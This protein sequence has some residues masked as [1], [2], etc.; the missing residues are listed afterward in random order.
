MYVFV[1]VQPHSLPLPLRPHLRLMLVA[2]YALPYRLSRSLALV[3]FWLGEFPPSVSDCQSPASRPYLRAVSSAERPP[4]DSAPPGGGPRARGAARRRLAGAAEQR[5]RHR[6]AFR[7]AAIAAR[8]GTSCRHVLRSCHSKDFFNSDTSRSC[9]RAAH[10]P[11]AAQQRPSPRFGACALRRG[12]P[13]RR[14][15]GGDGEGGGRGA[16]RGAAHRRERAAG[17][18]ARAAETCTRRGLA[19]ACTVVAVQSGVTEMADAR[20][21][22]ATAARKGGKEVRCT[23]HNSWLGTFGAPAVRASARAPFAG[24]RGN[25]RLEPSGI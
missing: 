25:P 4:S 17:E 24:V 11:S 9:M 6:G 7:S 2:R 8:V 23:R 22:E 16:R 10:S 3:F 5:A 19:A 21:K 13:R 1:Y 12:S 18:A 20:E 14:G 15:R